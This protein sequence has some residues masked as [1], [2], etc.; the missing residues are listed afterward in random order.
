MFRRCESTLWFVLAFM[1]SGLF[2]SPAPAQED[3]SG[4]WAARFHED[5]PERIPGPEIGDYL[6]LPINNAARLR[7]DSWDATLVE[8]P[9]NQCRVHGSDY[10]WRGPGGLHIWQ[11]LHRASQKLLAYHTH[12]GA[13]GNEQTIYMD[14]RAHP[15]AYAAHT[16]QGFSTGHW[17][18]DIL[19]VTTDHLKENWVRRNGVPRSEKATVSTHIMRHGDYLTIA[20]I[21][22]DPAYLTEPFIRTTDYVAAPNQI[23]IAPYPCESV[24]EVI[25]PVDLVPSHLPGSN[26]FLSE[27]PSEYGIP[28]EAT[29]GGAETMYP[30]YIAKMKGMKVLPRKA[31][32]HSDR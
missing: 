13:W 18:G 8:L 29:R 20:V 5:E 32:K 7:A 17:E 27:F 4:Y 19:A 1:V 6:G 11:E 16:W 21:V 2:V 14:G 28:P 9:E 25:R 12:I 24:E 10:A 26:P 15:P 23:Q 22:Y 3:P 31:G 30:E